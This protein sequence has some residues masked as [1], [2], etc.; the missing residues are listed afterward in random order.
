MVFKTATLIIN[1]IIQLPLG[2]SMGMFTR[3][4]LVVDMVL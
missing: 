2:T 4:M 1:V 3:V